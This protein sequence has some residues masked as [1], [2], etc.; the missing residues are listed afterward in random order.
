MI[1][2]TDKSLQTISIPKGRLVQVGRSGPT[3][4]Y[5][6]QEIDAMLSEKQ[7]TLISGETIKTINGESIL[8]SGNIQID[9]SGYYTKEEIDQKNYMNEEQVDAKFAVELDDLYANQIKTNITTDIFDFDN[10]ETGLDQITQAIEY[11][12]EQ[13]FKKADRNELNEYAKKSE[14]PDISNLATKDEVSTVES[15]IPTIPTNVSSFNNDAGYLTE[16]SLSGY[17]TES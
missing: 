10:V 12:G 6:K 8:G 3:S 16:L 2:I 7:D 13:I 11:Q 9:L 1:I 5:S 4:G 14:I 15:K 17:A